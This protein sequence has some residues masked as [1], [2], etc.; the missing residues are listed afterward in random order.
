MC[1]SAS[2]TRKACRSCFLCSH[3]RA[4]SLSARAHARSQAQEVGLSPALPVLTQT[5]FE[6]VWRHELSLC[7]CSSPNAPPKGPIYVSAGCILRRVAVL[8]TASLSLLAARGVDRFILHP[9][10][11][12][13]QPQL[14]SNSTWQPDCAACTQARAF[15]EGYSEGCA[16]YCGRGGCHRP[17]HRRLLRRPRHCRGGPYRYQVTVICQPSLDTGSD[18]HGAACMR[19]MLMTCRTA[20]VVLCEGAAFKKLLDGEHVS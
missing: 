8:G 11:K 14:P 3:R 4:L 9:T 6:P 17:A 10:Q 2:L 13:Y 15:L 12:A 18:Y 7:T 5:L 1:S 19:Y 20:I 16:G